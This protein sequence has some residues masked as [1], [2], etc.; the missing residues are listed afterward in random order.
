M[1]FLRFYL[2]ASVKPS[3]NRKPDAALLFL[4]LHY[5]GVSAPSHCFLENADLAT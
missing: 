4:V 5:F 3:L 1:E 2:C